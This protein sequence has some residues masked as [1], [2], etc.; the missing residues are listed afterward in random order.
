M[1]RKAAV[2]ALAPEEA[3]IAEQVL[4]GGV[5][6][7]RQAV[8]KQ[9][10]QAR[11]QG[12]PEVKADP[13]VA[14]AERLLPRLRTAEWHDRA[15]AALASVD[16]VDLRD[17]RSV[18]VAAET[19]AKSDDTRDLAN[20]LREALAR[21]VDEEQSAW[22]DELKANLDAGRVVR[23]LRL[24][25]RP[26]KAGAPLPPDVAGRL[27]E[28]ADA[29]LTSDTGADRWSTVLDALSFSPV[30]QQVKPQSLPEKPSDDLLGAVRRVSDRVPQI[31][32]L[33]GIEPKAAPRRRPRGGPG[34]GSRSG[35]G[36]KAK[37]KPKPKQKHDTPAPDCRHRRPRRRAGR[38]DEHTGDRR[39][40]RRRRARGRGDEHAVDRRAAPTRRARAASRG[41][42]AHRRPT[43]SPPPPKR[44]PRPAT[45]ASS[46]R[47]RSATR[48]PPQPARR[49]PHRR[50][51]PATSPGRSP[52]ASPMTSPESLRSSSRR[53][54]R[55][56][57]IPSVRSTTSAPVSPEP[58][59]PTRATG[60]PDPPQH[61]AVGPEPD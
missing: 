51:I 57:S 56:P 17:L 48:P 39:A 33:F 34:G 11:A 5:P 12:Q 45:V 41:D 42:R 31:A 7:V 49:P 29:A 37:A 28:A 54:S 46:L 21:R 10:E 6:A 55:A 22:L 15:E 4:R 44:P 35:G 50:P 26:P 32:A 38:G 60:P 58:T 24:S 36:A 16:E 20:Q 40:A 14:I 25:S 61:P 2:D 8:D 27:V 59:R 3:V 47:S 52:R 43:S 53:P 18:V 1:H 19:A 9:N 30:R 23:A 13:L